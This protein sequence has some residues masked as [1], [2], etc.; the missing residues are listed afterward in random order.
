MILFLNVNIQILGNLWFLNIIA[1]II[2]KCEL[3]LGV[4][5]FLLLTYAVTF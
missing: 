3:I 5:K 2:A 4:N 1:R